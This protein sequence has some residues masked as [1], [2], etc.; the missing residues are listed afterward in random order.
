M[1]KVLI[2]LSVLAFAIVAYAC[3]QEEDVEVQNKTEQEAFEDLRLQIAMLNAQFGVEDFETR[4]NNNGRWKRRWRIFGA[5]LLGGFLGYIKGRFLG[6]LFT[7]VRYSLI[8]AKKYKVE[9][10]ENQ[11]YIPVRS[12]NSFANVSIDGAEDAKMNRLDSIG[13]YHNQVICDLYDEY[14]MELFDFDE[15]TCLPLIEA[16][17][18]KYAHSD[19]IISAEVI[20]EGEQMFSLLDE[21]DDDDIAATFVTLKEYYPGYSEEF[22]IVQNYCET[23]T[24]FET[25]AELIEYARAHHNLLLASTIS[26]YSKSLIGAGTGIG[27]GSIVIWN[28]ILKPIVGDGELEPELP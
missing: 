17:A 18:Q 20:S 28:P 5:D 10:T 6:S 19:E 4:A 3:S 22:D 25:D 15:Q 7:G 1:K 11:M 9:N 26:E 2:W 8:A 23:L 21:M 12:M 24:T 16:E 27:A 14:G 13:Y